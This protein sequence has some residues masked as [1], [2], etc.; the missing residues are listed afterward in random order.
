MD[1]LKFQIWLTLT[2]EAAVLARANPGHPS[3][4]SLTC[5]LERH[6]AAVKCQF[7]AFSDYVTRAEAHGIENYRL[8][9]WTKRHLLLTRKKRQSL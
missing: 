7:D 9:H 2:A 3:L 5:I 4:S 8:Y 1:S 6:N